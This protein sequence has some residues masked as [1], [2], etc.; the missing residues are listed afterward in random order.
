MQ[1]A[2]DAL[3][4]TLCALLTRLL[5]FRLVLL[6]PCAG[7]E[8]D[9]QQ[10]PDAAS[11]QP[12]QQPAKQLQLP[13]GCVA[14]PICG[15]SVREAFINS[16][17]DTCLARGSSAAQQQQQQQHTPPPSAADSGGAASH[18]KQI[19]QQQQQQQQ[20]AAASKSSQ[21]MPAVS[22]AGAASRG[23]GGGGAAAAAVAQP[24]RAS[25]SSGKGRSAVVLEAPPKL[26]FELLKERDLKA[27]LAGLGLS[28]DGTKKVRK[29]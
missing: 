28:N 27:K 17:V 6:L 8:R 18:G 20:K 24:V 1:D 23:S 7:K 11:K 14:C 4:H 19:R 25:S 12:K 9:V 13:P 22:A 26:C 5:L 21:P 29:A 16:H 15:L 3:L 2:K 10:Q